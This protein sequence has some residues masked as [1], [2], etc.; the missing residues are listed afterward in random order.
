[1]LQE[2]I[3]NTLAGQEGNWV[4]V[5]DPNQAIYETFTGQPPV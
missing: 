2:E 3:L 4:R 5:G 1:V